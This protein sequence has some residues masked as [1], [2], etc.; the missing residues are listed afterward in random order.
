[1]FEYRNANSLVS[2]VNVYA[3]GNLNI[4]REQIFRCMEIT[5]KHVLGVYF[6][7]NRSII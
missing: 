2:T 5:E 1:M 6:V 4:N 7:H 3:L